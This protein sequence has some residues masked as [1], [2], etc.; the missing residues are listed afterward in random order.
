M[1]TIILNLFN[2]DGNWE[3]EEM[4]VDEDSQTGFTR[5][6]MLDLIKQHGFTLS[7]LE[8]STK[9]DFLADYQIEARDD[10]FH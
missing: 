3:N 7:E 2:R 8:A 1:M 4:L 9:V 6:K 5:D 10:M